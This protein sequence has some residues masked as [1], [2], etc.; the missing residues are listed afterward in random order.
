MARGAEI[1][2]ETLP[3]PLIDRKKEQRKPMIDAGVLFYDSP[4]IR[5]KHRCKGKKMAKKTAKFRS[6]TTVDVRMLKTLAREKT[7]TTVIA[8]KLNRSVGATYQQAMRLGV[9]LGVGRK[10]S[11]A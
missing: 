2:T 3:V 6:W 1:Q 4:L 11:R 9:T 7:K 10:K 5:L 8:R